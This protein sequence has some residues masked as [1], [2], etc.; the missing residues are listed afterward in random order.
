VNPHSMLFYTA[1]RLL[2]D[3]YIQYP[4]LYSFSC[5]STWFSAFYYNLKLDNNLFLCYRFM[6]TNEGKTRFDNV[7]F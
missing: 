3:F 4:T 1:A 7:T 6:E 2:S 5:S